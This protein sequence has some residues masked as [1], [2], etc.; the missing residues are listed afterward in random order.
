VIALIVAMFSQRQSISLEPLR[1]D[2]KALSA[3][4]DELGK[5]I[6]KLSPPPKQGDTQNR[7]P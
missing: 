7:A 3:K 6:E 4:V 5:T 2:V 1:Q